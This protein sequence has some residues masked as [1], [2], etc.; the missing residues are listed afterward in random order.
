MS[1]GELVL[2]IPRAS[3]MADP[4][5]HGDPTDGLDGLR[6]ARRARRR[7]PAARR[8]W[9][10]DRAWKQVIPYL[11]LRDGP[12]YF[13]MRR[14]QAGGDAR[15]HDRWSIGVGGHLN[16]GDGDLAG[17][18]R[19]EWRE[20]VRADFEP[21]FTL[22]GLLN[23]DTT[24]VGSVHV[25]AVYVADAGGRPVAIRETDK[26]SGR[27]RRP[28]RGRGGRRP[29]GDVERARLRAP[30]GRHR[31]SSAG[32]RPAAVGAI[33]NAEVVTTMSTGA[34]RQARRRVPRLSLALMALGWLRVRT[35]RRAAPGRRSSSCPR[36]ASSTSGMAK[37]LADNIR[38]AEERGRRG[39]RHQ[40][41]HARRQPHLDA[42]DH[43]HAP[44]GQGPGDRLGRAR[45]A[46][47]RRAPGTFITLAGEHRAHGARHH[48]SAP[49]RRSA[50]T[51][52]TSPDARQEGHERRLAKIAQSLAE[53]RG[54]HVDWAVSTV[55]DAKASPPSEAVDAG[56]VDGIAGDDRGGH[57][58]R[59]RQDGRGRR[60]G[61]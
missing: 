7:V 9:R 59:Q 10:S 30:R 36:P 48:A 52:R 26:L 16:P 45:P 27:L 38:L 46:A 5:W 24:D 41:Q 12:R 14:T 2:V 60:R 8:R 31:L 34:Q 51:A 33:L 19:R 6:G 25:G 22:I 35:R 47:S 15:L 50:A 32:G 18:L 17:G 11:V 20:E 55:A 39:G 57:R 53:R 37:Y 23:D 61:P 21:E 54:R 3:I 42:R 40:A 44:R 43:R 49:R 28:R 4:G 1:E 56:A 29:D 58:V 13:L